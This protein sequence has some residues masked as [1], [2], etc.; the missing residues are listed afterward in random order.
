M[1]HT[2]LLNVHELTGICRPDDDGHYLSLLYLALSLSCPLCSRNTLW[3][4]ADEGSFTTGAHGA[5][6][7]VNRGSGSLRDWHSRPTCVLFLCVFWAPLCYQALGIYCI[8]EASERY[9]GLQS[10]NPQWSHR[11]VNQNIISRRLTKP[12]LFT[13]MSQSCC[14]L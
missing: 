10:S 2:C 3:G 14:T 7:G 5:I 9:C 6:W 8:S 4:W 12:I 11:L 13:I 1:T